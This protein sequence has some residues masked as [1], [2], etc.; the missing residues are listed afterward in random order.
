MANVLSL[1]SA[2]SNPRTAALGLYFSW[3]VTSST[4]IAIGNLYASNMFTKTDVD[5]AVA[6]RATPSYISTPILSKGDVPGN[7]C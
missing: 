1:I 7:R 6:G 2:M 5:L 4:S 3:I